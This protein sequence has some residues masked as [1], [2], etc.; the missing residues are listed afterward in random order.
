MHTNKPVAVLLTTLAAFQLLLGGAAVAWAW[1]LFADPP[2]LGQGLISEYSELRRLNPGNGAVLEKLS[3]IR[4]KLVWLFEHHGEGLIVSLGT[5][6]GLI[7]CGVATSLLA[8]RLRL[9]SRADD[10]ARAEQLRRE[11]PT[12]PDS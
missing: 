6:F 2:F 10:P 3:A 11:L 4:G 12:T 8:L 9:S 1:P 5:G 7:F